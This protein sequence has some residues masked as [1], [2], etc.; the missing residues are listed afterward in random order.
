LLQ[1]RGDG[2][3]GLPA[4]DDEDGR[5]AIGIFGG[6]LAQVEPVR[7]AKIARVSIAARAGDAELLLETGIGRRRGRR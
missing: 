6:R 2:E 3:P 7:P 5:I 4:A 1:P